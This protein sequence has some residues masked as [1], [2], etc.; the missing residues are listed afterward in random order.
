[1][2]FL[3]KINKYGHYSE[4]NTIFLKKNTKKKEKKKRKDH[5]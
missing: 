4:E 5:I 2:V 3:K 1:M